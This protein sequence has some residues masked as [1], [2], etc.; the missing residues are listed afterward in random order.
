MTRAT[1]VRH[2]YLILSLCAI[3]VEVEVIVWVVILVHRIL[4]HL[5]IF[6]CVDRAGALRVG[7]PLP[8]PLNTRDQEICDGNPG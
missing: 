8:P 5:H 3:P 2:I 4:H 7:L 6:R 1:S